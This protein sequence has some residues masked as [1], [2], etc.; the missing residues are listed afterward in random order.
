MS[1]LVVITFDTP[2]E[3]S[4]LRTDIR[5]LE[6]EGVVH[7]EDAAVIMKDEH[8][9]VH[10]VNETDKTVAKG[11]AIGGVLGLLLFFMFPVAGIAIGAAGGALVG[12]TMDAGV[13]K[14]F[15]KEVSEELKPNNSALFLIINEA[16]VN[17]TLAAM[18]KHNGKVIQTNL[19]P[20][21]E[22]QLRGALHDTSTPTI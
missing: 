3:A 19:S 22:E 12:A 7:M 4:D 9:K 20:E 21:V 10:V 11:A 6:K 1:S 15:V 5:G 14:K 8:G 17:A 13:D 18:R 16:N 2:H